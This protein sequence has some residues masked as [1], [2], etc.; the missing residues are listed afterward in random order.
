MIQCHVSVEDKDE[1]EVGI[2]E[3]PTK[4]K[5]IEFYLKVKRQLWGFIPWKFHM[6]DSTLGKANHLT[7]QDF[8]IKRTILDGFLSELKV[9]ARDHKARV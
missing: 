4:V 9:K 8:Q 2:L 3:P 5:V 1:I 6:S 7:I